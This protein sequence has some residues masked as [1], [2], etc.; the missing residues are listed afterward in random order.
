MEWEFANGLI[1]ANLN[2]AELRARLGKSY[3]M[4][5]KPQGRRSL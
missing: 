3:R 5:G 4:K 2:P 1:S